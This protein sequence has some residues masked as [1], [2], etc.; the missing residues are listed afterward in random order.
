MSFW[1]EV[2]AW[3]TKVGGEVA[4]FVSNL[5]QTIAKNGGPV[6]VQAAIAAVAAAEATGK[7]G[8]EK[9]ADA[10]AAVTSVLKTQGIPV[11]L[12]AVNSAI[13]AAVA[14]LTPAA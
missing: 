8:A 4:S 13:E 7:T 12:N 10:V 3:F 14:N 5:A 6:L 1:T 2:E 11:V 9:K